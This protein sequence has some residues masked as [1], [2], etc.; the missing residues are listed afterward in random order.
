MI[1]NINT[2]ECYIL[3][4]INNNNNGKI[5][6]EHLKSKT[7]LVITLS[8]PLVLGITVS[9]MPLQAGKCSAFIRTATGLKEPCNNRLY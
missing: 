2:T 4:L 5:M 3:G 1:E 7:I 6:P 9:A 8:L